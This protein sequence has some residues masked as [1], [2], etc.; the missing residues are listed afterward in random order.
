[1]Q[2]AAP[3]HPDQQRVE[4]GIGVVGDY[5]QR[6]F[7]RHVLAPFDCRLRIEQAQGRAQQELEEV[8]HGWGRGDIGMISG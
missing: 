5:D 6:A 1:M 8:V 7:L 2:L 3:Q 4:Q